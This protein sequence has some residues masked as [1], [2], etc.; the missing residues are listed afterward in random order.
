MLIWLEDAPMYGGDGDDE[1]TLFIDEII[2]R[3][4]SK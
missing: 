4:M 1:V 2:T 3:K